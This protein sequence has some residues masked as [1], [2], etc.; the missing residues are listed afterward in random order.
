MQTQGRTGAVLLPGDILVPRQ[1][2][3]VRM[4][5][6][7]LKG[8]YLRDLLVEPTSGQVSGPDRDQ[9]LKPKAIEVLL[10]LAERPFELVERQAL[11]QAVWGED[12]G[13]PEALSHAISE[14]RSGL[15][16]QA[17][18]PQLI[19]TVPTRGYRLLQTPRL[20]DGHAAHDRRA[21]RQELDAQHAVE[22]AVQA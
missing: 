16:D 15:G 10:Y 12:Q 14:L 7:L 13:S 3:D 5:H 6:S 19:Q 21:E 17:D 4:H 22:A 8:F 2:P 1:R 20:V 11:L 9:H 18:D